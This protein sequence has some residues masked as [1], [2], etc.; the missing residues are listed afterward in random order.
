MI[1]LENMSGNNIAFNNVNLR[2][3]N[4]HFVF[5]DPGF[6]AKKKKTESFLYYE[7]S[8]EDV[9]PLL[10]KSLKNNLILEQPVS[11]HLDQ[12]VAK[13]SLPLKVVAMLSMDNYDYAK[14]RINIK[15]QIPNP[16]DEAPSEDGAGD[17][18]MIT[19]D[20]KEND[21]FITSSG[22]Q[23]RSTQ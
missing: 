14:R 4:G 17:C 21:L 7:N 1:I 6:F 22:T 15:P 18:G 12:T 8:W 19:H 13:K 16:P 3:D 23:H 9:S 10:S 2:Y 5:V 20:V 11:Y